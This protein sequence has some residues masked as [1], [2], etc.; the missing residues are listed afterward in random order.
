MSGLQKYL[1]TARHLAEHPK[2]L[3]FLSAANQSGKAIG[4]I[5]HEHLYNQAVR[6]LNEDDALWFLKQLLARPMKAKGK[7]YHFFLY[8]LKP[9]HS[10]RCT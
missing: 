5:T 1:L 9:Y 3:H 2:A 8:L 6:N 4:H 7:C 10:Y